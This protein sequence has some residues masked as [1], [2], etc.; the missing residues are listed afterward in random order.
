MENEVLAAHFNLLKTVI[1]SGIVTFPSLFVVFG[2]VPAIS[3]SAVAAVLTFFGLMMLCDCAE[4]YG[5]KTTTFT[6][7]LEEVWPGISK[8]FDVIVFVKCFGVSISYLII[9]RTL[10]VY[11]AKDFS[12][13]SHTSSARLMIAYAAAMV[14]ICVMKDLKSLRYTSIVGIFGVYVCIAGSIYN[15]V[16][17]IEQEPI[18]DI[19]AVTPVSS[20]WL[21]AIGQFVFSFTCHQNIFSVRSSLSNP[22]RTRMA[23]VV[24]SV[25]ASALG[26]YL[27][28]SVIIYLTY[29]RAVASN[30]FE[31]FA[32][33]AVKKGVFIFYIILLTC[34]YPLQIYPARDCLCGWSAFLLGHGEKKLSLAL[35]I[36]VSVVLVCAGVLVMLSNMEL[37]KIQSIIGGTASTLM[38]NVVPPICL[39][40]LPRKKSPIEKVSV[41]FL[42]VYA[43]LAFTGVCVV[44]RGK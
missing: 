5:S 16:K 18:P 38:C 1:G 22:S 20:K 9:I 27:L 19:D 11:L 31:S 24:G 44:F 6:A 12:F 41:V 4:F 43:L 3:F 7:S 30:V 17:K 21:K 39:M 25:L 26:F 40:R 32:D 33:G 36:V 29:G 23:Q 8:L 28:F 35:R 15:F 37:T 42:L 13:L 34:S 2:M 10:L 14:P